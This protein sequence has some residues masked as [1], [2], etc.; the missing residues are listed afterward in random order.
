MHTGETAICMKLHV[1][2]A[3]LVTNQA[4]FSSSIG[5]SRNVKSI[6][7]VR[8]I[9]FKLILKKRER[10]KERERTTA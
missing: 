8:L 7:N 10:K 6:L 9:T 5:S 3:V 1:G 4:I 2:K